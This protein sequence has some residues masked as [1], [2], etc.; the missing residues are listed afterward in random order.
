MKRLYFHVTTISLF[1]VNLLNAQIITTIAGTGA[2]GYNGD[3]VAATIARLNGPA[4]VTLDQSGNIVIADFLNNRV[5]KIDANGFIS[6]IAGTGSAGYNG[7]NISATSAHLFSPESPI[8][9]KNGNLYFTDGN[10]NRIRKVSPSGVITTIAGTG[11]YGYNG[12]NIPATSAHLNYPTDGVL[13]DEQGNVIISDSYNHRIRKISTD[14]IITTIAGTGSAGYNGD[15]I[16]ATSAQ[17]N[18]PYGLAFDKIGNIYVADGNNN[19]IRKIT[20]GGI[21]TTVA[22]N[23]ASGFS[24]DNG[25]ATAAAIFQPCGVIVDDGGNIFIADTRNNRVRKVNTNGIITTICGTGSTVYNG[26]NITATLATL[27]YP[28][29][30]AIDGTGNL[31]IAELGNNR[32]RKITNATIILPLTITSFTAIVQNGS[33]LLKWQT[34]NEI[35]TKNFII[36][37]SIDGRNFS[38]LDSVPAKNTTTLNT[39]TFTD[40]RL[41]NGINYYRLKAADKDGKSSVS[42]VVTVY[43]GKE[44][45]TLIHFAPNPV[46]SLANLS[47]AAEKSGACL[48]KITDINGRFIQQMNMKANQGLNNIT[49]ELSNLVTG[50]YLLTVIMQDKQ[51][52]H[53]KFI[54]E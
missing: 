31:L 53:I 11:T 4:G 26:D 29:G 27:N 14:G 51:I 33:G 23:G 32:I 52:E 3:G 6:T 50:T 10:N 45:N 35:N 42:K 54:K 37:K 39:Y 22:G 24:G 25:N 40:I 38:I 36:Q 41:Q 30:L 16:L 17:L 7:D 13:V 28:N 2:V 44:N 19:R 21:I 8:Y 46:K 34:T 18:F 5:R 9:D 43:S 20:P 12:D 48:L 1:L 47:F 49:L 15:N